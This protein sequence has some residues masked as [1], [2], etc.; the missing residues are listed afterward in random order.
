MADDPVIVQLPRGGELDRELSTEAPPSI[1]QGRVVV[2]S[3]AADAGGELEPPESVEPADTP[4]VVLS[5]PS[6]E[7]LRREADT[8][9]RVIDEAGD[10]PEPLVVEVEVGEHLREDEL[11]ALL[12]AAS[13]T[14]RAV[15]LR[16][17]R[18]A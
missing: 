13:R 10:G 6:P 14:S 4:K 15:I 3:L 12:D 9:R 1:A 8:V 17:M 16:V 5:L 11:Q 7:S 2:E 18:D